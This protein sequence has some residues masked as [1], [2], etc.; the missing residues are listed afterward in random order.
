MDTD[1]G[2]KELTAETQKLPL[3][4]IGQPV[5]TLLIS[6]QAKESEEHK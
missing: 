6:K 4:R 1:N 5:P 3:Y 2:R